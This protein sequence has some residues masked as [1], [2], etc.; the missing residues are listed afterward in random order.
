[1]KIHVVGTLLALAIVATVPAEMR[2]S[3]QAATQAERAPAA[4]RGTIKEINE[5]IL[6][7]TPS[8]DK[9]AQSTFEL[10]PDAK[11]TGTIEVGAP[12]EVRF[13]VENG[14]KVV[15]ELV[16]KAAKK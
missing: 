15:T 8:M 14:K 3:V 6:V 11:R 2:Y 9:R 12:V 16:G 13:Y 5:T 4:L 7:I 10:T 1:M